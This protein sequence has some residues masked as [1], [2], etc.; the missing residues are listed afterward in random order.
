MLK[1]EHFQIPL[2]AICLF[3]PHIIIYLFINKIYVQ[4]PTLLSQLWFKLPLLRQ[5]ILQHP[6]QNL[7]TSTLRNLI[8]PS[9]TSPQL[10]MIRHFL[11]QPGYD[12]L[13]VLICVLNPFAGYNESKWYLAGNPFIVNSYYSYIVYEIITE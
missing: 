5:F 7:P 1:S 4:S 3:L 6:P 9:H 8:N 2:E 10:L 12:L 11:I 13:L